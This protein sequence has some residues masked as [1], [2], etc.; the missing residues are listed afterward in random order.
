M[1][2]DQQFIEIFHLLF[3]RL[4]RSQIDSSLYAIKGG[5]NLRFFFGSIRYSEDLDI[6]VSIL[7]Q[8]SLKKK[9]DKLLKGSPLQ[10]GLAYYGIEIAQFSAPKQTEMVQR[11]KIGIKTKNRV[12]I[13]PTKIEFSRRVMDAERKA[14]IINPLL[15]QAYQLSPMTLSHYLYAAAVKQK[16]NALI[17]R[18]Q[19]QAR[20]IF[21][22][23]LLFS[24]KEAS[25]FSM[26]FDLKK[27]IDCILSISF[28]DYLS[29]VVA[30]L[31]QEVSEY[32]QQPKKW[33][34]MQ[35]TVIDNLERTVLLP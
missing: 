13:I 6:D 23:H 32:Y 1:T 30:Y 29:Q 9:I 12:M 28:N 10:Q 18:S 17:F 5:C 7:S 33:E 34:E 20:D 25:L 2:N 8:E 24:R 3:L 16:I 22:L 27:A 11:W 15:L 14:E 4:L 21:D 31:E 35:L 26:K 19:T